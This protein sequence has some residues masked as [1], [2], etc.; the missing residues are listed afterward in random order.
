MKTME[1]VNSQKTGTYAG[2]ARFIN[3]PNWLLNG[4]LDE[5][6]A[7]ADID[8]DKAFDAVCNYARQHLPVAFRTKALNSQSCYKWLRGEMMGG[9]IEKAEGIDLL[10]AGGMNREAL[11]DKSTKEI[12]GMVE[13]FNM[14]QPKEED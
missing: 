5:F 2:Q 9:S 10:V 11:K 7:D 6:K 3:V 13:V 14:L 8:Q 1:I 4:N 12:K